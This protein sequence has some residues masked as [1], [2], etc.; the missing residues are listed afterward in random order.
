M[1]SVAKKSRK[2][3]W[4]IQLNSLQA[5]PGAQNNKLR[6]QQKKKN[7]CLHY[8][9]FTLPPETDIDNIKDTGNKYTE[10]KGNLC[11]DLSLWNAN[12]PFFNQSRYR[13]SV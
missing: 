6:G 2:S 3:G 7:C 4:S 11:W 13:L 12:K 8:G 5:G 9:A 1:I 10:P